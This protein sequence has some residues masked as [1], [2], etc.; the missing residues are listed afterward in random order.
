[1]EAGGQVAAEAIV[2]DPK[3]TKQEVLGFGAAMTDSTCY[4]L[5]QMSALNARR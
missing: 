4:V 1:M 5:S 2:L 3:T